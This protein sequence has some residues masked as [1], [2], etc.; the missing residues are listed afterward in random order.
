LE[1][2]LARDVSNL[3]MDCCNELIKYIFITCSDAEIKSI[4]D[5]I[6]ECKESIRALDVGSEERVADKQRLVKLEERLRDWEMRRDALGGLT[7]GMLL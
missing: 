5:D 3:N 6:K 4:K 1:Y 7:R 2:E